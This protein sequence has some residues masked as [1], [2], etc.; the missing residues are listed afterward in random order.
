VVVLSDFLE[1]EGAALELVTGHLGRGGE[2]HAIRVIAAE[3]TNP[4]A[5]SFTATDPED[6]AIRRPF[7]PSVREEYQRRFQEWGAGLSARWRRAGARW[8]EI[9][10]GVQALDAIRRVVRKA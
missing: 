6:P 9:I 7:G 8:H 3:E 10:T 2:V 1:D 5:G 4:P